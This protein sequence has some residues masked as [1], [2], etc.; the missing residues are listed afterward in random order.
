[1]AYKS[2]EPET[3]YEADFE[4]VQEFFVK[5]IITLEQFIEI[6]NYNFGHIKAKKIIKQNLKLA[7]KEEAI[8]QKLATAI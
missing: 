2:P 8:R 7:R 1:M 4:D 3:L 6:L 5:G